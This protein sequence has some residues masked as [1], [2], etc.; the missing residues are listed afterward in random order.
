MVGVVTSILMPVIQVQVTEVGFSNS[1]RTQDIEYSSSHEVSWHTW[2]R[3]GSWPYSQ[4][5]RC[6]IRDSRFV[7]VLECKEGRRIENQYALGGA[8]SI[9]RGT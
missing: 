2:S 6:S 7:L 9:E 1:V 8:S 3:A 4:D 5:Q